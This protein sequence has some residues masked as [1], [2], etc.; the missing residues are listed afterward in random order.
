MLKVSVI[1][2]THNCARYLPEAIDSVLNQ[3]YQD[4][5]II[6][7][8]DGS[9]DNTKTIIEEYID[10]FPG[11]IH[12]LYQEHRGPGSARNL[13]IKKSSGEYIAF[14]DSDD[15]WLPE[16]MKKQINLLEQ[17]IEIKLV[18]SDMQQRNENKIVNKSYL[19]EKGLCDNI[20]GENLSLE[21]AK[22]NFIFTP[23]VI[24]KKNVFSTVGLFNEDYRIGED[25]DMWLRIA[26]RFKI[27]IINEPLVIRRLRGLSVS[28]NRELYHEEHIK[29][30]GDF[31]KSGVFTRE[32]KNIFRKQRADW[33]YHFGGYYFYRREYKK[34]RHWFTKSIFSINGFKAFIYLIISACPLRLADFLR[35]SKRRHEIICQK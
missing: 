7:V 10:K 27:N 12:Y 32:E 13:G 4:F 9:T 30:L 15:L 17:D 2:P 18:F 8:D 1:I 6:V 31:I 28:H 35:L 34:A 29:F 11:K 16:K 22:A 5:E 20:Q 24:V 19:N 23:T 21:L 33:I 25:Y 14:Q 3:T 26:K